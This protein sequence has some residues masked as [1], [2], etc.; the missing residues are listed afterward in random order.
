MR[1][2]LVGMAA[3]LLAFAASP[4][5]AQ[6]AQSSTVRAQV[7][8]KDQKG[9]EVGTVTLAQYPGGVLIRGELTNLPPGWHA[10]HVHE[11][12]RC[13]PSFEAAG[14]HLSAPGEGHG[15]DQQRS[16]AGDLPNIWG[17][18]DGSTK[19]EMITT[20]LALGGPQ[21]AGDVPSSG[22]G[23]DRIACGAIH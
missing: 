23:T 15:L 2:E 13:E 17:G 11:T 3:A 9:R 12:G 18:G 5:L 21:V 7:A 10:I 19:F 4:S 1:R 8:L 14:G 20:R 6:P 22:S 16:H